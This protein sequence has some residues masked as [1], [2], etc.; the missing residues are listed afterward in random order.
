MG[1]S[2]KKKKS[3]IRKDRV[4]IALIIVI[5]IP[6]LISMIFKSCSSEKIPVVSQQDTPVS[7]SLDAFENAIDRLGFQK[8]SVPSSQVHNGDLI[9]I[10][11][12]HEFTSESLSN[13][14]IADNK[15][16]YYKVLNNNLELNSTALEQFNSLMKDYY[17]QFSDGNFTIS[18]AYRNRAEQEMIYN[19]AIDNDISENQAGFSEHHSGLGLDLVVTPSDENVLQFTEY[20][21]SSWI[22]E[23]CVKYGFIQRYPESKK[24]TTGL[25]KPSHLRYVSVPHS[26]YITENNMCLE[27]YITMLNDYK[28]GIKALRYSYNDKQYMIYICE[29]NNSD[30]I[31]VY[32]P[33]D[34]PYT[35]SGNNINAIIVTVEM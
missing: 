26:N 13:V 28:F 16:D 31:D 33:K 17:T 5:G 27:E 32:V 7:N 25:N 3:H 23:N 34:K 30:S 24:S 19:Q 9:L 11:N 15:N 35:I 12:E 8:I 10:N 14:K 6:I 1:N 20:D 21:N 4:A 18:S 2:K 29:A 22:L